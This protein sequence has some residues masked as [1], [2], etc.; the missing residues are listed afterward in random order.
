M[1]LEPPPTHAMT[2]SG[3]PPHLAL[4]WARVS[5]PMI[6]WKSRTC[7]DPMQPLS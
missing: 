6:D 1:A 2:M 5:R 3:R 7:E 4:H